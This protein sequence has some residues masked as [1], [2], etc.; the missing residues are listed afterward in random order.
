MLGSDYRDLSSEAQHRLAA[1]DIP[2]ADDAAH[3][4][5]MEL[6]PV[7]G[8]L[9][10]DTVVVGGELASWPGVTSAIMAG[11]GQ[12]MRSVPEVAASRLGASAVILGAGGMVLSEELGVVWG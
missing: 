10:I 5:G 6:A 8:T 4:L 12:R 11:I 9:D 2:S 7:V 3:A 1:D